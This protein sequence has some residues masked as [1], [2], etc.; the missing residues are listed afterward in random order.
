[1]TYSLNERWVE[2]MHT[3]VPQPI[4]YSTT[5]LYEQ[6]QHEV[7]AKEYRTEFRKL[8]N[9]LGKLYGVLWDQCDSRM[10]NKVQS[11]VDYA[12]VSKMLNVLGL[13]TI[14]KGFAYPMIH[15]STT[16]CKLSLQKRGSSTS[17]RSIECP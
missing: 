5:S 13:L 7:E 6:R 3:K 11:D 4:N 9:D 17:G 1:M 10:K 8:Q 2:L 16:R 14:I 15:Q 12:E